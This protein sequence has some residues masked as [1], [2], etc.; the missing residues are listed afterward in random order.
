MR[1]SYRRVVCLLMD[2]VYL[3]SGRESSPWVIVRHRQANCACKGR[4]NQS[5][6][7]AD[8]RSSPFML[9]KYHVESHGSA[10][11]LVQLLCFLH[12]Q[13]VDGEHESMPMTLSTRSYTRS[14]TGP[15]TRVHRSPDKEHDGKKRALVSL[16][17]ALRNKCANLPSCSLS[18]HG[19]SCSLSHHGSC[20][21]SG[22]EASSWVL[23]RHRQTNC[24]CKGRSNRKQTQMIGQVH[25]CC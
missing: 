21:G 18:R 11:M 4:S 1:A 15:R 20:L 14:M 16:Y 23:V 8:D 3:G 6:T 7:N 12:A 5:Q 24:A 2:L 25:S 10:R 9:S 22:R 19:Y 13:N 17:S